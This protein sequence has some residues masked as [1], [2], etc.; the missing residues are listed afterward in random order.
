MSLPPHRPPVKIHMNNGL[1]FGIKMQ[2]HLYICLRM[3]T[4]GTFF[5]FAKL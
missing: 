4:Q 2:N 5:D 3:G 1:E